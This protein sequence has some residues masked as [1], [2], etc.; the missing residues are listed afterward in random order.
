DSLG[1]TA[2]VNILVG[3]GVSVN[4]P[5]PSTP[6]LGTLQL[7]AA[8]GA[9]ANFTWTL[10]TNA[11]AGSIVGDGA[12]GA[13][14]TAGPNGNVTDVVTVSDNLGN[15]ASVNIT[16]TAGVTATPMV[17]QVAPL[18]S[19]AFSVSGGSGTGYKWVILTN[20]SGGSINKQSGAYVAGPMGGVTD[21]LVVT[22]SLG[23]RASPTV[24]VGPALA[25]TPVATTSPP[26]GT[27]TF[28][29]TGGAGGYSFSLAANGSN[30]SITTSG[31][32]TAGTTGNATDRVQVVD[33]NGAIAIARVS[34]GAGISIVPNAATAT[35]KESIAFLASGGSGA[36]YLWSLSASPSKGSID[37]SSGLYT[38]G[39]KTNVTDV[40]QVMDPLGNVASA[41]VVVG[42]GVTLAPLNPTVTPRGAIAFQST[43]GSPPYTWHFVT[44]ASGATVDTSGKYVAGY[45]GSVSDVIEVTDTVGN[46][47]STTISVGPAVS[48]SPLSQVVP[49]GRV[50]HFTVAGG[51]GS[52]YVWSIATP[53]STSTIDP[54]SGTYVA[55]TN[56]IID[57]VQVVDSLGNSA[58]TTVG[59]NAKAKAAA[60][61]LAA[62]R[63]QQQQQL[64]LQAQQQVTSGRVDSAATKR[65]T[66][67]Q[68][69][70]PGAPNGAAF[71][72]L[73]ILA[74]LFTR[75]RRR[76][77]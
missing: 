35:A 50:I 73:A 56:G 51:S 49:S 38:A 7:T 39:K 3:N 40:V 32:Y 19:F 43:G 52:G 69:G 66:G 33:S 59:V 34:V 31:A 41:D 42:V 45:T 25:I 72:L 2:S 36:G 20:N 44:N 11:S 46:E 8:G 16:V 18:G 30:G 29:A 1:N 13:S 47:A 10:G 6:P 37:A 61:K 14:Y 77:P 23:N 71:T 62:D 74:A 68:T 75:R 22:D 21:F 5:S 27:L 12:S 9:G 67:C 55:G 26:R 17:A 54:S 65:A 28:T 60:L 63:R 76:T 4:P 15:T 70:G 58:A 57:T 64:Q 24:V 48:I 53:G